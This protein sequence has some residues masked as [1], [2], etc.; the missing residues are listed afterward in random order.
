MA[1]FGLGKGL[2]DLQAE[3]GRAPEMATLTGIGE[4]VVVRPIP[5]KEIGPNPD[6][7]RKTFLESDLQELANSIK[8]HGVL[9]PII[10][11]T[12]ATSGGGY[13]IVAGERRWRASI[14]AGKDTIPA[15]VKTITSENAM[16]VALIENVQREN[17]NAIEESDAYKSIMEKC[18]YGIPDLVKL[19]GK[20]E[21]YIRN[22]LRLGGLPENVKALVKSGELSASH[23]R[24]LAVA[25]DP[26]AMA[27]KIISKNL[28][29]S[30]AADLV[31]TG[32]R[33]RLA[34]RIIV[35][36][37]FEVKTAAEYQKKIEDALEVKTKVLI[38]PSRRG[39]VTVY[40]KN[41]GELELLTV[42]LTRP[43]GK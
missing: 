37:D 31:K 18:E 11:R 42:I 8:E 39:S 33:N 12:A 7:P 35:K 28:S 27:Q 30:E 1:K 40:F 34:R 16:E 36:D 10:V 4:R 22:I 26:M 23:A 43:G 19:I 17:L 20:S 6:Q 32:P 9:Q 38:K 21:S 2:K 15:L 13:E 41:I 5:V 24:T 25:E 29:V 14:M 3:M